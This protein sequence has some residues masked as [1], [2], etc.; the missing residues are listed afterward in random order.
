MRRL[1]LLVL[2]CM[3][4]LAL[5]V[6][7]PFSQRTRLPGLRVEY[8]GKSHLSKSE[9]DAIVSI[10]FKDLGPQ[11]CVSSERSRAEEIDIIRVA[12]AALHSAAKTDLLVQGSGDCNCSATGNCAFWVIRKRRKDFEVLL[13][14]DNVQG[15]SVERARTHGYR[16]L[17]TSSHGSAT[18]HGLTLYKFD[19]K[20]YRQTDCAV[21]E[22]MMREDGSNADK[23]TITPTECTPE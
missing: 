9:K 7:T 11:A 4:A 15:F 18:V 13:A 5:A 8:L 2:L 23:P 17:M 10:V 1:T 16:D 21:E 12:R 22:Y 20:Q 3:A 19:G 14:T 6:Q